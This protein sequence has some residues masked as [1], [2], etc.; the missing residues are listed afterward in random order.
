M[1]RD[2]TI[3]ALSGFS[4]A[5]SK[6]LAPG[7]QVEKSYEV[8]DKQ[9][10]KAFKEARQF[11]SVVSDAVQEDE[12]EDDGQ[13]QEEEQASP[14]RGADMKEIQ[15]AAASSPQ[16]APDSAPSPGHH[17]EDEEAVPEEQQEQPVPE[18]SVP[19][20]IEK[21]DDDDEYIPE[22]EASL[23]AAARA[24]RLLKEAEARETTLPVA[25]LLERNFNTF[26]H[27]SRVSTRGM[28]RFQQISMDQIRESTKRLRAAAPP[29]PVPKC[30]GEGTDLDAENSTAEQRLTLTVTKSD[31]LNMRILGQFNKG[32][33]LASRDN[34]LFIID[35]HASDEKYNFE[36]LQATTV[37]QNQPLVVPRELELMT[38]DE[39]AVQDNLDVLK[40]NGF[41]VEVDP[42][43]PTGRRCRLVSLPMS[44]ETVFGVEGAPL[45]THPFPPAI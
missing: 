22:K 26:N 2:E 11:E 24:A 33:I 28:V 31:F 5:L 13:E 43:M 44:R 6:F 3:P 35:Q 39:I 20:G 16:V 40:R 34:E 14:D 25:Q 38:M 15:S 32:F 4:S 36:T 23:R 18:M 19:P 17:S 8:G 1:D 27:C 29:T 45:L 9:V 42:E 30:S 12:I 41:V 21:E 37:V 7:T 10:R